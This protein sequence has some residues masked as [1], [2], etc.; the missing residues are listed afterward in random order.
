MRFESYSGTITEQPVA[1]SDQ[2]ERGARDPSPPASAWE[3]HAIWHRTGATRDRDR[4][5]RAIAGYGRRGRRAVMRVRW[6]DGVRGG[7]CWGGTA[8]RSA[9]RASR[10]TVFD[11]WG[12]A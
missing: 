10:G 2:C 4:P 5:R 9:R 3:A 6:V 8:D 12:I 11:G 1:N 7:R